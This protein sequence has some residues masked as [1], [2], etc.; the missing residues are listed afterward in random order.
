M[1]EIKGK[2]IDKAVGKL[3][4]QSTLLEVVGYWLTSALTSHGIGAKTAVG[5][6][7]F[8]PQ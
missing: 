3:S 5:Y 7:Y 6:G 1:P 4:S 8:N 2:M